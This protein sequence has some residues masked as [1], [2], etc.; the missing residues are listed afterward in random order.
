MGRFG[1][2]WPYL[3]SQYLEFGS[4]K[5]PDRPIYVNLH[6]LAKTYQLF[7]HLAHKNDPYSPSLTETGQNSAN[8]C[9]DFGPFWDLSLD[10]VWQYLGLSYSLLPMQELI[11][12][13]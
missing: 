7:G 12:R 6:Y 2:F 1:A 8:L 13:F 4:T 11:L 5:S 9:S 10:E 3:V